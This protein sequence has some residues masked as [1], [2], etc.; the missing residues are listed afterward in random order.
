MVFGAVAGMLWANIDSHSYQ[1]LLEH[2][3]LVNPLVGEQR[4]DGLSVI[5]L[6]F[7]INDMLMP[8]FF[9]L[10][11][12]EILSATQNGGPF[13][14]VRQAAIP[15]M[16]ALGGMAA[17]AAIFVVGAAAW[18]QLDILHHGW[19]IPCATDV[20][21]SFMV[22]KLVFGHGHPAIPFLLLLAIAD[23]AGGLAILA[24][25]YPVHESHL[26][27]LFLSLAASLLGLVMRRR[28]VENF[29]WYLLG[30]GTLSWMGFQLA[31]VHPALGL[32][33][34]LPTLPVHHPVVWHEVRMTAAL[35]KFE[36]WWH[37]PVQVI[38]GLFAWAN[39]GVELS[40]VG[41]STW[42]VWGGLIIGKPLGIYLGTL[43]AATALGWGLPRGIRKRD[44]WVIGFAAGIGFTVSLFVA[45][46]AFP[47]GKLQDASKMGAL[48]SI[49][50]AAPAILLGRLLRVKGK[51]PAVETS[52]SVNSNNDWSI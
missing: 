24:I 50:A 14:N 36:R 16:A 48:F 37:R 26:S 44:L 20:A 19:A 3:L 39:A 18:G 28:G 2:P 34:I 45:T 17:P 1:L 27:W 51:K 43:F 9:A 22:A 30:P 52:V 15:V 33:P 4:P 41:H 46:V 10:A 29:W 42:L 6:R 38:L 40:S 35:E 21:F 31:G 7:I 49:T 13:S 47:S 25:F 12:K 32:L 23:D 5:T 8:F 11:G